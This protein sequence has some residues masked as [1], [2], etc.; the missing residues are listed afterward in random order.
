MLMTRC[1]HDNPRRWR[2]GLYGV[3]KG[4]HVRKPRVFRELVAVSPTAPNAP[5][6]VNKA[7]LPRP[8]GVA[9]TKPPY[10]PFGFDSVASSTGIAF[11]EADNGVPRL[12]IG[13]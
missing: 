10:R 9:K 4:I 2:A 13:G 12:V 3:A 1:E 6:R 8:A 7:K 11:C 5:V